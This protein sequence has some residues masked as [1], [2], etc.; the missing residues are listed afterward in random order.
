MASSYV[1]DD[2][3]DLSLID[4]DDDPTEAAPE[5]FGLVTGARPPDPQMIN[6]LEAQYRREGCPPL[7]FIESDDNGN[8]IFGNAAEWA[9]IMGLPADTFPT[10]EQADA[11]V[12]SRRW[13]DWTW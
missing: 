6:M 11:W 8:E 5:V 12:A 10:M 4:D 3:D 7:Q 2:D 1:D 9:A 13:P